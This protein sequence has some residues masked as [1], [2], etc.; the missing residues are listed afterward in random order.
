MN[1]YTCGAHGHLG[2]EA[3]LAEPDYE[4]TKRWLESELA[5]PTVYP[6]SWLNRYDAGPIHWYWTERV[7][8]DAAR[9]FRLGYDAEADAVTYPLR[10]PCGRVLGVVRRPLGGDGPKYKYPWGVDMGRLLFNYTPD[11]RE[12]VVLCEGALDAIALWNSGVHAF[13]IYGSQLSVDQ[14]NLIDRIDPTTIYTC[15]DADDAGRKVHL[16]TCQLF[17]H[18]LVSRL[19]WPRAWGKDIDEIGPT[20]RQRVLSELVGLV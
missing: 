10:D 8:D 12:V 7:G 13:A 19:T 2:G 6:E 20:R 14:V 5:E 16:Q 1:C 17:R 4:S 9:A 11:Q 15:Y 18:R 3:L